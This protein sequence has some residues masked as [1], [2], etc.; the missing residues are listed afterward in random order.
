VLPVL[1]SEWLYRDSDA[2]LASF[3]RLTI[4]TGT[5]HELESWNLL[6]E[7]LSRNNI[8][9]KTCYGYAGFSPIENSSSLSR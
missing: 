6:Q 1:K 5:C 7:Q 4:A 3:K 8:E 2:M 9:A